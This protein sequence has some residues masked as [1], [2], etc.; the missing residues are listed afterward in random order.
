MWK[1]ILSYTLSNS[2]YGVANMPNIYNFII[3]VLDICN[4]EQKKEVIDK[5]IIHIGKS[6]YK[7]FR[8][9]VIEKLPDSPIHQA[10]NR[11]V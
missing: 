7:D 11:I 5:I 6:F 10:M 2:N 8:L 4:D 1:S 3:A 9:Y